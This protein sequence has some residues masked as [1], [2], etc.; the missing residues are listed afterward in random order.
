MAFLGRDVWSIIGDQLPVQDLLSLR[1]TC[2][3]MNAI[4]K[5]M[6]E[7][8]YRA[9]QWFLIRKGSK[10]KVKSAVKRH[11]GPVK[12]SCVPSNHPILVA[13]GPVVYQNTLRDRK[14]ELIRK[15]D[16]VVSNCKDRNHWECIVPGSCGE[17]PIDKC[18][19]KKL[20]IYHYLIE[21]WRFNDNKHQIQ[22][23]GC[24]NEFE[25]MERR[26]QR[27]LWKLSNNEKYMVAASEALQSLKQKYAENNIFE[28][29]R[30]DLYKGV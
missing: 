4:V 7:R 3:G 29:A 22:I 28:G 2:H 24:I 30:I 21:C 15:G 5:K 14:A 12:E 16:F 13:A 11:K 18:N 17:I 23:R 27:L 9:Y 8:W 26:R 20:Y 1:Q 25:N 10:A 19:P 6:H